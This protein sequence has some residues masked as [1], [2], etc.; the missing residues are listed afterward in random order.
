MMLTANKHFSGIPVNTTFSSVHVPTN[1]FDGEPKVINAI[2]WTRKLDDTFKDNYERDPSLSWQYFGSSTGFLRQYPAMKWLLHVRLLIT[3][4]AELV[5][6]LC[7]H[8]RRMIPTCTTPGCETG[9]SRQR[10]VRR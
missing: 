10:R 5:T 7:P 8:F 3:G 4:I 9:T 1:V 2:D 6:F